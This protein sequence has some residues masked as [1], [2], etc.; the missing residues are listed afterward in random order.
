MTFFP[1]P[2]VL[3]TPLR[4]VALVVAGLAFQ[5]PP[6][7]VVQAQTTSRNI[8][9]Q[10]ASLTNPLAVDPTGRGGIGGTGIT[11][12]A[13]PPVGGIGGTGIVG[14][15]TGFAS[16]CVNDVEIHLD[17]K[18]PVND[19]GVDVP[20]GKLV[21]GQVV[22]VR[23]SGFGQEVMANRI[24][25]V[26]VAVGPVDAVNAATGEFSVL[27]QTARLLAPGATPPAVGSWV[28]ISG[29]REAGGQIAASHVEAVPPQAQA[30]LVGVVDRF[31]AQA[32]MVSGTAVNTANARDAARAVAGNEVMVSGTWDGKTLVAQTF[33]SEPTLQHIGAVE[34]V[35]YEG[36]VHTLGNRTIDLGRGPMQ[37]NDDMRVN[38]NDKNA[39]AVN[40]L[41]R[42]TG[43]MG[44]DKQVH[45]ERTE[46]FKSGA[47]SGGPGEPIR[48]E[49]KPDDGNKSGPS[50]PSGSGAD[51]SGGSGKSGGSGSN[52]GSG[53]SGSSGS[54][55]GGSSGGS[56]GGQGRGRGG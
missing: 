13:E 11:V 4:A 5:W 26:H 36:Y 18:T 53:S 21:V 23:A 27:G 38:G 8:C 54:T 31:S 56:S 29:H 45:I 47:S 34:R 7:H 15:I 19:N 2:Q 52:S 33:K 3:R 55:S 32:L 46:V 25:L 9:S 20:A 10:G 40:Q 28:R 51:D 50:G 43:R 12:Q 44:A 6:H 42:I 30:Q 37:M 16:I 17:A 41:V 35:V 14:V 1:V 39:L 48:F 49:K 24:A 22:A